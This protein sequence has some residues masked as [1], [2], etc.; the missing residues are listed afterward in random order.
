MKAI[1]TLFK[2][3]FFCLLL[4]SCNTHESKIITVTGEIP[5]SAIGKTLHHEHI[6]VDFIGADSISYDRWNKDSVIEK[7]LP[8]LLEIK[9]L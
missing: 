7:V 1:N 5:A 8:Y 6:L 2:I 9:K 3:I 4:H